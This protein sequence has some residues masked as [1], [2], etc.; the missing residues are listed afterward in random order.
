MYQALRILA[1][2]SGSHFDAEL[3]KQ[4]IDLIGLYPAGSIAELSSGEIGIVLP[5]SVRFKSMPKVLI[6]LDS[7]KKPCKER[8]LDLAKQNTL[9]DC[10]EYKINNLLP[11]GSFGVFIKDYHKNGLVLSL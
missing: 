3:V 9:A 2:A 10:S 6:V 5:V 11:D 4:F 7:E 8:V 1:G